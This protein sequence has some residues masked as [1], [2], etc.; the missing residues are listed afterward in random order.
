MSGRTYLDY[1]AT[2]P[3]RPEVRTATADA[4]S[5]FG[6]PSSVHEEGRK[7]R[8]AVERARAQVA[9]LAGCEPGEVV[10]TSGASESNQTVTAGDWDLIAVSAMEHD[11]VLAAARNA[12]ARTGRQMIELSALTDGQ[13]D[14]AK[15]AQ[16]LEALDRSGQHF[17]NPLV[18]VQFANGETGVVQPLEHI[19]EIARE[20]G[21]SVHTDAVQA[22]GRVP[23]NFSALDVDFMSLSAHKIGGPKGVGALIIRGGVK[24]PA[25]MHGGGQEKGRRAGT[26]NVPGIV[27]FGTA[28]ECALRDLARMDE[29]QRM[30]D[31]IEH[32]ASVMPNT[33]SLFAAA[34]ARLPNTASL[35]LS[36]SKAET[37]VI[38]LDLAGVAVSAGSACS[39]GKVSKSHVLEAV[40]AP[41]E[42]AE[43]TIRVS[44]GWDT[45]ESDIDRFLQAWADITK[46]H[47]ERRDVA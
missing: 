29:L 35:A 43:S 9:A 14:C 46:Q 19:V 47:E 22:A 39:S 40:N 15:F 21:F 31:R 2:A 25:L 24:I 41:P 44:L 36:G 23:V 5:V 42:V 30:R 8:A 3:L 32:E 17:T 37:L 18:S 13:V 7:A 27:G 45:T 33:V 16:D 4:L 20:K 10:F 28:A 38:A 12:V 11:S 1:N 34:P 6:N 26:E